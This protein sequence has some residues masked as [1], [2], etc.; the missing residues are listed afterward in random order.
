MKL[1]VKMMLLFIVFLQLFAACHKEP[2]QPKKEMKEYFPNTVGDYW[3]YEVYDSSAF[4]GIPE[5]TVKVN[6]TS[7]VKLVDG[8]D[9]MFGNTNIL[10]V[11]TLIM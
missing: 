1:L 2:V 6:I 10:G 3:E 9:A 4:N 11:T 8:I 5:Y 7:T